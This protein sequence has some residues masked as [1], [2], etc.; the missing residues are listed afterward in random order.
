[1][2][3]KNKNKNKNKNSYLAKKQAELD[4]QIEHDKYV[5]PTKK[6]LGKILIV[7]LTCAMLLSGLVSLILL[8]LNNAGVIH[9]G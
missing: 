5:N 1:M 9:L 3:K 7:V 8:I 2:S 4:K 6:P